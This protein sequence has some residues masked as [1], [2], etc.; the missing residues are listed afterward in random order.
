MEVR[1]SHCQ[2][3]KGR[4]VPRHQIS[5]VG[6]PWMPNIAQLQNGST[7]HKTDQPSF[8]SIC[9]VWLP[10]RQVVSNTQVLIYPLPSVLN[11]K[12][13]LFLQ[14][15]YSTFCRHLFGICSICFFFFNSA[16]IPIQSL[17]KAPGGSLSHLIFDN[18]KN[19]DTPSHF[20]ISSSTK[21]RIKKSSRGDWI[22]L[23]IATMSWKSCLINVFFITSCHTTD[24]LQQKRKKIL[25]G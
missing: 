16:H 25:S 5:E 13:I 19:W 20:L 8:I 12:S 11:Q 10:T 4:Q 3:G 17:I 21:Y 24:F 7:T 9:L 6:T 23:F 2:P 1:W 18:I 22:Y 15:L 14:Y